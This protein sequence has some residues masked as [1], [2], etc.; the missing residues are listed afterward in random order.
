MRHLTLSVYP[1]PGADTWGVWMAQGASDLRL[2][3]HPT[4]QAALVDARTRR[5]SI[6]EVG[7]RCDVWI[8][9]DGEN[10]LDEPT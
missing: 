1:V 6:E 4:K 5:A 8:L 7:D 2:A 3:T 10:R 9:V